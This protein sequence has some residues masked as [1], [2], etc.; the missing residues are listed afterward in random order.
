MLSVGKVLT[1]KSGERNEYGK[2]EMFTICLKGKISGSLLPSMNLRILSLSTER[3][4]SCERKRNAIERLCVRKCFTKKKSKKIKMKK[5]KKNSSFVVITSRG[6]TVAW[7][8]NYSVPI[9]WTSVPAGLHYKALSYLS[10]TVPSTVNHSTI[11]SGSLG[12]TSLGR[13]WQSSG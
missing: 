1:L 10:S 11:R 13:D 6:N 12:S 5:R 8:V 3:L 4:T 2:T 7:S 9:P